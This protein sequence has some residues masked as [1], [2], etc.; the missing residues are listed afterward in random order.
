MDPSIHPT[1]AS[2]MSLQR[3][4]RVSRHLGEKRTYLL[5]LAVKRAKLFLPIASLHLHD[6]GQ[7]TGTRQA[8]CEVEYG[9]YVPLRDVHNFAVKSCSTLAS[10]LEGAL[11]RRNGC[12]EC[13]LAAIIDLAA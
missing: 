12:V 6:G 10:G 9:I 7:V 4:G 8:L 11:E 13:I 1:A 2:Q 3:S 5:S